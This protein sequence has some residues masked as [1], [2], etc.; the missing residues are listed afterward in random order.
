MAKLD[1]LKLDLEKRLFTIRVKVGKQ[2]Q[3]FGG[4]HEKDIIKAVGDKM[5]ALLG[6]LEKNQVELPGAIKALGEHQIK[7]RLGNGLTTAIKIK[8]EAAE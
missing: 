7:L 2:G 8:V 3:V 4:V 1:A 5:P 6:K